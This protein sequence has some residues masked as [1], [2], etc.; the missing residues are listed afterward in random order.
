MC[1]SGSFGESPFLCGAG[2]SFWGWAAGG[3]AD[4]LS[5]SSS[6]T[7]PYHCSAPHSLCPVQSANPAT[8]TPPPSPPVYCPAGAAD[9]WPREG[10]SA[11]LE[12]IA[13]LTTIYMNSLFY[14]GLTAYFGG[15]TVLTTLDIKK[16]C[17]SIQTCSAG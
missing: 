8:P 16:P 7:R 11:G 9:P 2:G 5:R 3:P 4:M 15:F 12:T 6:T 13:D 1:V 10:G 14:L 17:V